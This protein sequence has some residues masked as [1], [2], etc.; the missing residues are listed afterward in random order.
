MG[1]AQY[2]NGSGNVHVL[3]GPGYRDEPGMGRPRGMLQGHTCAM[4]YKHRR[5]GAFFISN[6]SNA[7]VEAAS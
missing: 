4:L 5:R 6:P 2:L 3:R 1:K 7:V